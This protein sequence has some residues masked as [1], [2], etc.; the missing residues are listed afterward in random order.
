MI[1]FMTNSSANVQIIDLPA[2]TVAGLGADFISAMAK[3]SNAFTVL[4]K[5]WGEVSAIV[6]QVQ[7]A[8]GSPSDS[9]S[10]MVGAMGEPELPA[11]AD[12]QDEVEGLLHYFAG[13]RVDSLAPEQVQAFIDAGFQL[14]AYA[15]GR[16][17]VCEHVGPLDGLGATTAWFYQTW[18]PAE[19]PVQ[20][21]AHHYEIYDERFDM[22]SPSSVVMICAPVI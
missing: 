9:K 5:L 2:L 13:I 15:P 10:W 22:V 19:G 11:Y 20:R 8:I 7:L 1:F 4:P 6:S 16:F 3:G 12:P 14:R 17:A 21:Y 18:L